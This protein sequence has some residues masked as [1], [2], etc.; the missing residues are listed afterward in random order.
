MSVVDQ[1]GRRGRVGVARSR[2]S[3]KQGRCPGSGARPGLW[4]EDKEA[5]R[6]VRF[7]ELRDGSS[8]AEVRGLKGVVAIG[9][10]LELCRTSLQ[11]VVEGWVLVHVHRGFDVPA[12]AGSRSATARSLSE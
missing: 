1:M 4:P 11:K 12:L 2:R 5:L 7:A 8:C 3:T 6:R 10:T 9:D